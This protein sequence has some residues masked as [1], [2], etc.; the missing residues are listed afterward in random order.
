MRD[1][2]SLPISLTQDVD[3]SLHQRQHIADRLQRAA[4]I[5]RTR[6][7]AQLVT[8]LWPE[9][10][11]TSLASQPPRRKLKPVPARLSVS[12]QCYQPRFYAFTSCALF[13]RD[14]L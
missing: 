11:T 4:H 9:A 8:N 2:K 10:L 3:A 1:Y 14:S 5:F 12:D 6:G 7:G 13:T